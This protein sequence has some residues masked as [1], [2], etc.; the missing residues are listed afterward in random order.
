MKKYITLLALLMAVVINTNAQTN[1]LAEAKENAK[2]M[3]ATNINQVMVEILTGV[4]VASGEVYSASKMAIG[5]AYDFVKKETPQVIVEFLRWKLVECC[6]WMGV[7]GSFSLALVL[8]AWKLS[9][10]RKKASL[11]T[12]SDA[13]IAEFATIWKWIFRA[14]AILLLIINLGYNGMTMGKIISAPRVYIIEY[15]VDA[16]NGQA[17]RR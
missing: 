13:E 14:A 3:V 10:W 6:I 5:Q 4:K 8:F 2:V 17:P 16:I 11:S 1:V 9:S 12:R 15:V 7:W